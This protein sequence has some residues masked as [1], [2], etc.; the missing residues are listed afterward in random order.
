MVSPDAYCPG[1]QRPGWRPH[2]WAQ[3]RDAGFSDLL[4]TPAPIPP[5]SPGGPGVW[6]AE[7]PVLDPSTLFWGQENSPPAPSEL[8]R[9]FYRNSRGDG[10]GWGLIATV[11][12]ARSWTPSFNPQDDSDAGSHPFIWYL[13]MALGTGESAVNGSQG[14][15]CPL[16]AYALGGGAGQILSKARQGHEEFS[17]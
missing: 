11:C 14:T 1:C 8:R 6:G 9:A 16:G 2:P 15:P 5:L 10:W 12:P 4:L 7:L 13:F 17:S 3:R